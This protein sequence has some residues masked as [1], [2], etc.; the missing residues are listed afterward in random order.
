[1]HPTLNDIPKD[2]RKQII[3]LLAARLADAIDL[4]LQTKQA[5][6]SVR[7]PQFFSL[8]ELFDA[9]HGRVEG[10]VDDLA[11]RMAQLG[12]KVEGTVAA[13]SKTSSLKAYPLDI[14]TGQEHLKAL[15]AAL[16]AFGKHVR[17]TIDQAA[18]LGDADTADLLTGISRAADKDL[19]F[20]EGHLQADR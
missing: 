4:S 13:V 20:V 11:E 6:W 19:W 10:A 18:K 14:T 12:G 16:A 7:G 17:A 2:T 5:H 15:A 3:R 9:I 1:M 8:H